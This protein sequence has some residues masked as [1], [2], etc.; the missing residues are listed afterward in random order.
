MSKEVFKDIN[1]KKD[2]NMIKLHFFSQNVYS[3]QKN[4]NAKAAQITSIAREPFQTQNK[5]TIE[6]KHNNYIHITMNEIQSE[7]YRDEEIQYYQ[8]EENNS[9]RNRKSTC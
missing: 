1:S 7:K 2:E 4:I 9:K 6:V 3:F 8:S 5:N